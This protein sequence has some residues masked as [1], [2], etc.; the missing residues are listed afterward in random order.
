[1]P[2]YTR[3]VTVPAE[4]DAAFAALSDARN[5]P[6]YVAAMTAARP[7]AGD[8]VHVAAEVQGRHEEGEAHF[9]VD[10]AQRRIA[11]AGDEESGYHG[12]LQVAAAEAGSGVTVRIHTEHEQD[13]AE[14]DRILDD[15]MA[16]IRTL[17]GSD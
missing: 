16:R 8:M 2:D 14:V 10:R 13:D 9:D 4:P 15:T 5:L 7:Q 17:L 11:W 12:S 1:M 6:R 3:S